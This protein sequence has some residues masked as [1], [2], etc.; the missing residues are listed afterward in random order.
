MG[1]R[2]H[3]AR[4]ASPRSPVTLLFSYS[5]S[6]EF[7]FSVSDFQEMQVMCL[8]SEREEMVGASLHKKEPSLA[9]RTHD[10]WGPWWVANPR[11]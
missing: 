8:V 2:Q 11:A 7:Y 5:S 3:P 6:L 10:L 9:P 1:G 4:P